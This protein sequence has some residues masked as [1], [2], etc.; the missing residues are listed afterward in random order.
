MIKSDIVKISKNIP[1]DNDYI[2]KELLKIFP[3]IVRWAVT[4]VDEGF[5]TVSVSYIE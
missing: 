1:I 5:L 2:E 3:D 4:A